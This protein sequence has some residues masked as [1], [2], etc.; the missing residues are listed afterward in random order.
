MFSPD[1]IRVEG[2]FIPDR[3]RLGR[4]IA[5]RMEEDC[6]AY[7]LIQVHC[8]LSKTHSP[9][10][11]ADFRAVAFRSAGAVAGSASENSERKQSGRAGDGF[12]DRGD[13]RLLP[14]RWEKDP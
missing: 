2:L 12:F 13:C 14:H 10:G 4:V 1:K 9:A 3:Y 5:E 11:H 7:S 8:L 6:S